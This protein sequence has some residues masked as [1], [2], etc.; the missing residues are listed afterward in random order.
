MDIR[1]Y[2]REAWDRQVEAGQNPW[3]LPV[4]PEEIAKA[5]RGEWSVLLTQQK[6]VP[7]AWFP[8]LPG[9]DLL[10]LASGGGQQ[11]P[12]F[13]AAGADVT[14]F[15]NS[16]KQLERDRIV[17]EREGLTNLRT[18]E[19]DARDLSMFADQSFDLVFNPVSTVF[20]SQVCPVWKECFRVLRPGGVLLVGMMNPDFYIFDFDKAD[21]G[22]LEVVHK[23]PYADADDPIECEKMM[24]KGWPLEHSHTLTDLLGGQLE[25]G[26]QL[27]DLYE[28]THDD[29]V[30]GEYLQT[31]IATRAL[32]IGNLA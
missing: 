21:Q 1:A 17:A 12:I 18:V 3:T 8:P 27:V 9:L 32:K 25:A 15:D 23:L 20:M 29:L 31:Y 4:S 13:A 7:R 6:P 2:N 16:P 5:R 19:G 30:I 10:A 14:V 24:V 26:F 11:G 22:I 28:D